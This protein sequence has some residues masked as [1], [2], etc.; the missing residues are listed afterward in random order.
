[1]PLSDQIDEIRVRL[2]SLNFIL[3]AVSEKIGE[4]SECMGIVGTDRFAKILE[5]QQ[6]VNAEILMLQATLND[7]YNKIDLIRNLLMNGNP[8]MDTT[9]EEDDHMVE[10]KADIEQ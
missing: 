5:W 7:Y 2:D 10:N 4:M 1:M 8:E 9:M 3:N 6:S